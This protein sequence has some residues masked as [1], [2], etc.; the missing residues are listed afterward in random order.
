MH[1]TKLNLPRHPLMTDGEYLIYSVQLL[2]NEINLRLAKRDEIAAAD[3]K[4]KGR[5]PFEQKM[6]NDGR[7]RNN[8]D[9]RRLFLQEIAPFYN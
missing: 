1:S 2:R 6:V 3:C 9:A 5:T 4:T 8:R 7:L